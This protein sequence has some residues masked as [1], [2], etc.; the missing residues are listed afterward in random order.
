MQPNLYQMKTEINSMERKVAICRKTK[1]EHKQIL[2]LMEQT[3]NELDDF[4]MNGKL[5]TMKQQKS[6][7]EGAT[8]SVERIENALKR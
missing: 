4:L 6:K 2:N 7:V 5:I 3:G 8:S 1:E